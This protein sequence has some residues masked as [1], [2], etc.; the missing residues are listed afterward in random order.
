M[1]GKPFSLLI[2][3]VL[4]KQNKQQNIST[5]VCEGSGWF[6]SWL[7]PLEP[8]LKSRMLAR[9]TPEICLCTN[10]SGFLNVSENSGSNRASVI[11]DS[12]ELKV[13]RCKVVMLL[14][15]MRTDRNRKSPV[16]PGEA[17]GAFYLIPTAKI[18]NPAIE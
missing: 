3:T 13:F 7:H 11:N 15:C 8:F 16:M 12:S 6:H 4:T 9:N 14:F 5:P 10:C 17:F 2:M 1:C 18:L